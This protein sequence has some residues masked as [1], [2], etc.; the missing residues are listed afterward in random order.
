M[1]GRLLGEMLVNEYLAWLPWSWSRH[2]SVSTGAALQC[3]RPGNDS[4][5]G[6][7]I[8]FFVPMSV[9]QDEAPRF[10]DNRHMKVVSRT[11]WPPLPPPQEIFL[12]LISLRGWVDPSA[13]L[14]EWQISGI[15]RSNPRPSDLYCS[16][17]TNCATPFLCLRVGTRKFEHLIKGLSKCTAYFPIYVFYKVVQIWP[18]LICV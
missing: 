8:L 9:Q 3:E 6:T 7:D 5:L 2:S 1:E 4:F 16:A 17:S 15:S 12:V 13:I 10:R 14:C 11:E 18:G